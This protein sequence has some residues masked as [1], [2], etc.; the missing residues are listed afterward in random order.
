MDNNDE[1]FALADSFINF[2]YTPD[3]PPLLGSGSSLS[4]PPVVEERFE[5][6]ENE[7]NEN[8]E[9]IN[10]VVRSDII[11]NDEIRGDIIATSYDG[12]EMIDEKFEIRDEVIGNDD[13][14]EMDSESSWS[15]RTESE[16]YEYEEGEIVDSNS[17]DSKDDSEETTSWCFDGNDDD[18]DRS[19]GRSSTNELEV[20]LFTYGL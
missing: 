10:A 11:S 20:L 17:D 14:N 5:N 16:E 12:G 18:D 4:D 7:V 9:I 19:Q 13:F 8:V 6:V 2:D 3:S 15:E 1:D